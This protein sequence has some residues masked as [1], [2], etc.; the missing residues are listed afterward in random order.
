M[1]FVSFVLLCGSTTADEV[2]NLDSILIVEHRSTPV[3]ATHD[4]TIQFDRNS[5]GRQIKLAD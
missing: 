5:R 1:Y 3:A 4:F 2:H